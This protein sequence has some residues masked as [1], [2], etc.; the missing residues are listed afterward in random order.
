V[1]QG[2]SPSHPP[3]SRKLVAFLANPKR[4]F[5]RSLAG[6]LTFA[7]TRS[8]FDGEVLDGAI[9][10]RLPGTFLE[11]A[12]SHIAAPYPRVATCYG[13]VTRSYVPRRE[14]GRRTSNPRRGRVA[15]RT[16]VP[17]REIERAKYLAN[18]THQEKSKM[19]AVPPSYVVRFFGEATRREV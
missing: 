16:D 10:P 18:A 6:D 17:C 5:R 11:G 7:P 4:S 15:R 8:R 3:C 2:R 12:T 9:A 1:A 19:A 14:D 13:K